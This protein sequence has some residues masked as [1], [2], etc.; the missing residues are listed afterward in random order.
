[1]ATSTLR[2]MVQTKALKRGTLVW[3]FFTPG[4]GHL[5]AAAG[6]EFVFLDAEHSGL[7]IDSM[8]Q[9]LRYFEAASI[10]VLA[11]PPGKTYPHIATTLDIGAEGLILPMVASAEEARRLVAHARYAPLGHRGVA[12]TVGHDRYT[13]GPVREKLDAA[14]RRTVIFALVETAE[15]AANAKEIAAVEGIDGLWIGHLDLSTSLGCAGDFEHPDYVAA[16]ER[17]AGAAAAHGKALGRAVATP[18]EGAALHRRGFDFIC[19]NTDS[20]LYLEALRGGLRA[21]G[22]QAR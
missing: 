8:K 16:V 6:S 5:L 10:P 1:M 13:A 3:E 12:L 20:Q 19:L 18:E 15:G 2:G 17:I 14:N 11:R 7:G 4:I 22:E 9:V 21:L